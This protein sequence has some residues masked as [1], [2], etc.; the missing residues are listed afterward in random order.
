MKRSS[1]RLFTLPSLLFALLALGGC[2]DNND[3][4]GTG[5]ALASLNLDAPDSAVSGQSFT[6]DVRA[7]AIGVTNV[8]N[9]HVQVTFPAPLSV[10]AVDASAGTTATFTNTTGGGAQV[11]WDLNTLDSNTQSTLHITTMGT[12]AAGSAAQSLT[13]Q[14]VLTADGIGAGDAD[15]QDS[16]Q[17]MPL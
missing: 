12:L 8:H 9:G 6:T 7:T 16:I 4:A 5:G 15:A 1:A 2:N 17:L 13:V 11:A 10:T 14:A 3:V